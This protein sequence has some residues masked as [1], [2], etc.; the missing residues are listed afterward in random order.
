VFDE[1]FVDLN[2][3]ANQLSSFEEKLI[4][5]Q[6]ELQGR[7]DADAVWHEGP[8]I[9]HSSLTLRPERQFRNQGYRRSVLCA[10]FVAAQIALSTGVCST[11]LLFELGNIRDF[12]R[13]W[14]DQAYYYE[15][16]I[17]LAGQLSTH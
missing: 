1:V 4:K 11:Q 15:L 16:C 17:G 13:E 2:N 12:D 5:S 6:E 3:G 14:F 8:D 7:H 9:K 10:P